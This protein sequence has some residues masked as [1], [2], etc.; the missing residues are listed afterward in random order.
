MR[1]QEAEKMDM[2]DERSERLKY[3]ERVARKAAGDSLPNHPDKVVAPG[4]RMPGAQKTVAGRKKMGHSIE[5]V[6]TAEGQAKKVREE[7]DEE[8][9]TEVELGSILK[10]SPSTYLPPTSFYRSFHSY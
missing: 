2:G 6:K 4:K 5:T 8:H 10:R 1:E 7:T 3:V 9:E